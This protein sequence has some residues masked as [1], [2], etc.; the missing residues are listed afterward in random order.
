MSTQHEPTPCEHNKHRQL[1]PITHEQVQAYM[2]RT[3]WKR[4]DA[5]ENSQIW[6]WRGAVTYTCKPRHTLLLPTDNTF[7]DYDKVLHAAVVELARV[8]SCC[9]TAL[10]RHIDATQPRP[11]PY[12]ESEKKRVAH[13]LSQP[14]G[15]L[16]DWMSDNGYVIFK[17]GELSGWTKIEDIGGGLSDGQIVELLAAFFDV[18]LDKVEQENRAIL[19]E[20]QK[21]NEERGRT[22]KPPASPVDVELPGSPQ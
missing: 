19:A 14:M 6:V 4:V 9:A 12:P 11:G 21:A 13:A 8:E 16:L 20:L 7:V 1:P 17:Q 2:A 5:N 10:I 18:D 15:E 22:A 3:D